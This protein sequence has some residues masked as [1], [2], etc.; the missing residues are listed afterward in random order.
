MWE[1]SQHKFLRGRPDLLNEI[2]RKALEPGPGMDHRIELPSEGA[3]ELNSLRDENR[4][5]WDLLAA[6]RRRVGLLGRLWD[7]VGKSLPG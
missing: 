5:M 3:A 2:K 1:V 7:V 4:R 6:E